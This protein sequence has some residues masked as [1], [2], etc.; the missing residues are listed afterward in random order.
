[1]SLFE[2]M[3]IKQVCSP[4]FFF[5]L[6]YVFGA[7]ENLTLIWFGSNST[8]CRLGVGAFKNNTT[9]KISNAK[10]FKH[11]KPKEKVSEFAYNLY[12]N[13]VIKPNNVEGTSKN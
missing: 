8:S 4:F 9:G 1:M 12:Y 10:E 2:I 7:Y 3:Y 5:W 6:L 11:T 13:I